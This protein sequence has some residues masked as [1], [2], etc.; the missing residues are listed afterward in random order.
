MMTHNFDNQRRL[1]DSMF[2]PSALDADQMLDLAVFRSG[3]SDTDDYVVL[4]GV[5]EIALPPQTLLTFASRGKVWFNSLVSDFHY[6]QNAV[7]VQNKTR[8]MERGKQYAGA[9]A[10]IGN[11]ISALR[12]RFHRRCLPAWNG[13]AAVDCVDTSGTVRCARRDCRT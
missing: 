1:D 10:A 3:F 2:L 9:A 13:M 4:S 6:Q 12:V 8:I 7:S 5:R 11:P